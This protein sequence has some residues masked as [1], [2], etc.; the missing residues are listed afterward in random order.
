MGVIDGLIQRSELLR[1]MILPELDVTTTKVGKLEIMVWEFK[2]GSQLLS[3]LYLRKRA[4]QFMRLLG[5]QI[6]AGKIVITTGTHKQITIWH[7]GLNPNLDGKLSTK[8]VWEMEWNIS[9]MTLAT[10][11]GDGVMSLWQSNLKGVHL[12]A[13]FEHTT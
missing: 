7:L 3:W 2:G 1:Q 11:E 9:G 4:I 8:K 6:L 13:V 12:P 10:T 5:H